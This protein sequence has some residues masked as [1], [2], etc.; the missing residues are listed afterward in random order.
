MGSIKLN[1]DVSG[2]V[3]I[4]APAVAGTQS[5]EF[6]TDVVLQ[7]GFQSEFQSEMAA[8]TWTSYTP[9]WTATGGTPAVGGAGGALSGAYIK[10]GQLCHV[11]ITCQLGASPTGLAG[12]TSWAFSLPFASVWALSGTAYYYDAT[13]SAVAGFA[14]RDAGGATVYPMTGASAYLGA[15]APFTWAANDHLSINA[16]YRVAA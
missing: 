1:G 9:T 15:S 14:V 13:G 16:T 5:F 10:I 3:E 8:L 2:H 11:N 6:P 4:S 7:S 12:T